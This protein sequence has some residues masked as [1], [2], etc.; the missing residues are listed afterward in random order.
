MTEL[1]FFGRDEGVLEELAYV[2]KQK[3]AS[4]EHKLLTI[5]A[6]LMTMKHRSKNDHRRAI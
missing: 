6:M 3:E 1:L 4:F 2:W 5:T